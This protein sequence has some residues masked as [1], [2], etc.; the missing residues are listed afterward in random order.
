MPVTRLAIAQ[1]T[2]AA[3]DRPPATRDTLMTA[4]VESRAPVVVL[5]A[6]AALPASAHFYS[7]RDLWPHLS[8]LPV[9]A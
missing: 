3:F 1:A 6:L 7:L 2:V 4:A 5:E 9:E 8:H